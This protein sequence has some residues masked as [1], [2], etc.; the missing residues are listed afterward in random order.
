MDIYQKM[1]RELAQIDYDGDIKFVGNNEFFMH[2]KNRPYVE[3]A[4][5]QLPKASMTLFS[6]GDYLKKEDLEWAP[7]AGSGC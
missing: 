7:S 6:N 2:R 5:A 4:R 1:I 3:Y